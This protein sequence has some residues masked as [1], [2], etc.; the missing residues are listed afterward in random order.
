MPF[1]NLDLS[2]AEARVIAILS[3]DEELLSWF[4]QGVDV[5]AR[6]ASFIFGGDE[7][8]YQKTPGYE[9]PERHLGKIAR[10]AYPYGTSDKKLMLE[11]NTGARRFG[12][13]LNISQYRAKKVLEVMEEKCPK[14]AEVYWPSIKK[15]AYSTRTLKTPQGRV[16]FFGD[17]LNDALFR[18]MFSY[19]PQ[20]TVS[21]Q[22]KFAM[23]DLK[24]RYPWLRIIL[25]AHD[26]FLLD[27]PYKYVNEVA[28]CGKELL[29]R[30]IDFSGCTLARGSLV[31][32]CDIESGDN[33]KELKKYKIQ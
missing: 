17:R 10:H 29:E 6:T 2:Q 32:P 22:T 25:E 14:I 18:E 33:Y 31:I 30:P 19:L 27:L 28:A 23:I 4:S 9:P 15:V 12:I 11:V 20:A 8:K 26:A 21:D 24:K 7:E 13:D 5:H 16:R 1:L 3:E